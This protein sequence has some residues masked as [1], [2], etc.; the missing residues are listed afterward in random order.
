MNNQVAIRTAPLAIWSLSSAIVGI[1]L[2]LVGP[3]IG[4]VGSVLAVVCGHLAIQKINRSSGT[5]AGRGLAK[6]GFIIGYFGIVCQLGLLVPHLGRARESALQ[7]ECRKNLHEIRNAALEYSQYPD[8]HMKFPPDFQSLFP[9]YASEPKIF[10]CPA[11][12]H[13]P[14]KMTEI[15]KWTD[16]VL[17]PNL[18]A[19]DAGDTVLAFSKKECYGGQGGNVLFTDTSIRWCNRDEYD[20]LTGGLTR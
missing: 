13:Q 16:Y 3:L 2:I 5:F 17:V 19:D 10:V 9:N 4:A 18:R 12:R 6:A 11:T 15:D 20:R 7:I 8:N 14:G 1:V